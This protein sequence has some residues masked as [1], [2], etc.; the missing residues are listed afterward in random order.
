MIYIIENWNNDE[1]HK[2]KTTKMNIIISF[3]FTPYCTNLCDILE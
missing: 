3:I 2:I 1:A